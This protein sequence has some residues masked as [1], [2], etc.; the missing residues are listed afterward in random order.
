[1]K[2]ALFVLLIVCLFRPMSADPA[3]H[4]FEAWRN[5]LPSEK[6]AVYIGW[7]NGFLIGR[8][9]ISLS[10]ERCLSMLTYQQAV[11]M[12]DKYFDGHPERWSAT[13]TEGIMEA[14]TVQGSTC[15]GKNPLPKQ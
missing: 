3:I 9:E 6:I 7:T 11:A 15:E 14:L 2:A 1:M 10:L 4:H 5:Q 8:G 12:I 13:L